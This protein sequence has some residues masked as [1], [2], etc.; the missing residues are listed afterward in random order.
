MVE[1]FFDQNHF[2]VILD[3]LMSVTPSEISMQLRYFISFGDGDFKIESHMKNYIFYWIILKKGFGHFRSLQM[4]FCVN[5]G[6][7]VHPFDPF[8]RWRLQNSVDM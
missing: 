7:F 8:L 5:K 4:R 2:W 6:S 3:I 1:I